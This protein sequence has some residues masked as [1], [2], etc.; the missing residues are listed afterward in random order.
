LDREV[1]QLQLAAQGRTRL[2]DRA[3][4]RQVCVCHDPAV[5]PMSNWVLP[6][7]IPGEAIDRLNQ[8]LANP[9]REDRIAI[10]YRAFAGEFPGPN[11][12]AIAA[13]L[14]HRMVDIEDR[15]TDV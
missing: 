11:K 5:A 7:D 12:S 13:I 6:Q 1:Q 9:T 15:N 2:G 8:V 14:A 3:V 10:Y 4:L